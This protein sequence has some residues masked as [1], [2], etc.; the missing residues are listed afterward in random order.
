MPRKLKYDYPKQI[1][2]IANADQRKAA[3]REWRAQYKKER[4][5]QRI[6]N[7]GRVPICPICQEPVY[8]KQR[9]AKQVVYC[10]A[11]ARHMCHYECWRDWA[12]QTFAETTCPMCRYPYT[13]LNLK[14]QAMKYAKP[15]DTTGWAGVDSKLF[16][17]DEGGG[18]E[19]E[20]QYPFSYNYYTFCVE[21]CTYDEYNASKDFDEW[22]LADFNDIFYKLH[23]MSLQGEDPSAS[24]LMDGQIFRNV[25]TLLVAAK[26]K[27]NALV[28]LGMSLQWVDEML[29]DTY[30][31]LYN[32][33]GKCSLLALLLREEDTSRNILPFQ[34]VHFD[35]MQCRPDRALRDVPAK[36]VVRVV[37]TALNDEGHPK[38]FVLSTQSG[39]PFAYELDGHRNT[40]TLRADAATCMTVDGE[41]MSDYACLKIDMGIKEGCFRSSEQLENFWLGK[42]PERIADTVGPLNP[43][44]DGWHALVPRTMVTIVFEDGAEGYYAQ[45]ESREDDY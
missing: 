26:R 6:R 30:D 9:A 32:N 45:N 40:V 39:Q 22:S 25:Q 19:M 2:D 20:M 28:Q 33:L 31:T 24:N 1:L 5:L 38:K 21:V 35:A 42:S 15:G 13:D 8:K 18:W 41:A 23:M 12:R 36:R 37:G 7:L 34:S 11:D 44:A 17:M 14:M 4:T 10:E 3:M 43:W 29:Q 16:S 27:K